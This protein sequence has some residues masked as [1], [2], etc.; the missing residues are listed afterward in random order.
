MPGGVVDRQTRAADWRALAERLADRGE[1]RLVLVEGT[2]AAALQWLSELLPE[3]P[4]GP[5][6]WTGPESDCPAPG[7]TS[8][9]PVQA[10]Q[11]LGRELAWVVWD[12]WRGNPPDGLAA[13]GGTLRAGGLLFWLMPALTQWRQFADPDYRR[14]GL[15]G[16]DAHPFA[17]R[18]AGLLAA[19]PS[20]LRVRA[21][22]PW[23]TPLPALAAPGQ[24]FR[25]AASADQQDLVARLVRFGLGRRRR[26]LVVT[27]D[28]G[29]G[30]SAALGMAAATLV[31]QGRRQ[32]LVTAPGRDCVE[33]LFRH[34]ARTLG[35]ALAAHTEDRLT[36][37]D[38][39]QIRFLPLQALL[40][41]RPEAEVVLVDEA[42]AIPAQRL[43]A[44]LLGWPR[45]AFCSTVHG[46]EG[47]GR[48]FAVRFRAVLDR[49][50][51]HWQALTLTT[52]IRWSPQDPLEPLLARLFLLS[53]SG[54]AGKEGGTTD[55]RIERWSPSEADEAELSQA[56]GLLVDA[57]YRTT[58]ADLRQWLDDPQARSWCA[59]AGN[60]I[61]AVLWCSVEGGLDAE[62][63]E[64]VALGRR[65]LRGHL[66][67]QSLASHTGMADAASQRW[68][69]VVRVAV[70]P[71][72]RRSGLGQRLVAAA[73][74]WARAAALDALGT[75]FGGSP[76]LLAFWRACG[77]EVVRV[78]F[79]Q[80]AS[81]GEFPLQ[82]MR[83]LSPEG[84]ALH[85][86]LH[87]RLARHWLTLVRRHW[88]EM[89][90]ELV[91]AISA[92]LP[93]AQALTDDDR[94]DLA[95]FGHG[96]CGFDVCLPVLR[97]LTQVPGVMAWLQAQPDLPLWCA[98]VLQELDWPALQARGLCRGQR[99]GEDRLRLRVRELLENGPEL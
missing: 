29:R 41:Q 3:L 27:A 57:H 12:G 4:A 17:G 70:E 16:A 21:D 66:L 8:I 40:E 89:A 60:R 32:V 61:V 95:L 84:E 83:A 33:T 35:S 30:K 97:A 56:F 80:E 47:T 39:G 85:E 2:R 91:A 42:A 99:D 18:M 68:L 50:T 1:R 67:P 59:W 28:R 98:A 62:L 46:Y 13:I 73:A 26:P 7:L 15:D 22:R 23:A 44:V 72:V 75:S 10:R 79:R 92:R 6:V 77:L 31:Q 76:E 49:Q 90:P 82:M 65:R 48:G 74:G 96:H 5:G 20:V 24:P 71:S 86:R 34:A 69:R 14:T 55:L 93:L 54:E 63:A 19:D 94:R 52:P 88:P 38:G 25:V 43:K 51:P 37:V 36:T 64:Q 45:V 81:S 53:A 11:W 9:P 78:G 58:P 87:R